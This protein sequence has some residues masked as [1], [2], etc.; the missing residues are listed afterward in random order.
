MRS[1]LP[2]APSLLFIDAAVQ[3]YKVLMD[4]ARSD[5][6]VFLIDSRR[7]GIAQITD[8]LSS[9]HHVASLHLVSHG[10]E[11]TLYL[12]NT[13]LSA[14]NLDSYG[15]D[16]Q[17]WGAALAP[18]ADVML[19]GCNVAAG[20]PGRA[21]VR[22]LGKL[23]GAK[24]AASSNLTGN[25]ALGGD[26]NLE[27]TTGQI[28]TPLAFKASIKRNYA[29]VLA[30]FT[31]TSTSDSGS[32]SLRQA[33]LDANANAGADRILF[34][35]SGGGVKTINLLTALPE[36]TGT[37][38]IDGFS[39]GGTGYSGP[40]LIRLDGAGAGSGVDGL[41]LGIDSTGSTLQGLMI[42]RFSRNGIL[43]RSN[44]NTLQGNFI[45]TDGSTTPLG[46][47]AIEQ[48]TLQ[49]PAPI[50]PN[51]TA[52]A[53]VG[54]GITI[55]A[56]A[57]NNL[58]QNNQIA[59]NIGSGIAVL[60]GTGN[61][62]QSNRLF[63]NL[64]LGIDLERLTVPLFG[65]PTPAQF[66]FGLPSG[67]TANDPGDADTG[68]NQS[69]N[70]P[71]L[72]SAVNNGTNLAIAGNLNSRPNRTYVL[73]F[74]NEPVLDA[75]GASEGLVPLGTVEVTTDNQGN[76]S[77]NFNASSST[78]GW[79]TAVAID[80][81]SGDTSEF[82]AGRF[83]TLPN[84]PPSVISPLSTAPTATAEVPVNTSQGVRVAD[85]VRGQV[86][87]LGSDR[88]G[89]A[90][91]HTS[92]QNGTW[93]YST[94]GGTTWTDFG[95]VSETAATVLLGETLLYDPSRGLTPDA[96][97]WLVFPNLDLE[98]PSNLAQQTVGNAGM[99]VNT[100][101]AS[102]D[103]TYAGYSSHMIDLTD[104]IAAAAFG[105]LPYRPV[106]SA[107]PV[108]DRNA[109]FSLEFDLQMLS[110][111][112]TR[113]G[114]RAGFSIVLMSNSRLPGDSRGLRGIELGFTTSTIFAQ[115][116]GITPQA[117]NV[118]STGLFEGEE[119]VARNTT[120]NT[121]YRV[122]VKGDRYKLLANG[123]E[124]L[125]GALRNY[126]DF[127][128]LLDPYE[129]PNFIFLGDN[130]TSAR[131]SFTLGRVALQTDNRVRFS[132]ASGQT[133]AGNLGFK[134]WDSTDGSA[135]GATGIDTTR[136]GNTSA[137]SSNLLNL[138]T[139]GNDTLSGTSLGDLLRGG[140]GR[141]ML[142]GL[143]G[144]DTL[145]GERGADLLMGSLG[146]DTLMGGFGTDTL[147]GG[148]GADLLV[149]GVG[150]DSLTGGLGRDRF[151][152]N[153]ASEGVD[154]I[155]DFSVIDDT[156][157]VSASGFGGGLVAGGPLAEGQLRLGGNAQTASERFLY[158]VRS[159]ELFFDA[160]GSGAGAAVLFA[161]LSPNLA[162]S[163]LNIVVV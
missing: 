46:N 128:F 77:F 103:T 78:R 28:H 63:S 145:M 90:V 27:F 84:T 117:P 6:D 69:Q 40:P 57:S 161:Q 143:E 163:R 139:D 42:T 152:F 140:L 121:T 141:D 136:G 47:G 23:M 16:L 4:G 162:L 151:Q 54:S 91:T 131:G 157:V 104:P 87:D 129:T 120:V 112:S 41:R 98:A 64:L 154:T 134:A 25:A 105:Q 8:V 32:G 110:E 125:A 74:F 14:D 33:I 44:G 119:S 100:A 26:W 29:G 118:P 3:D 83:I 52:T 30:D 99:T 20:E 43:V 111:V 81:D 92:S 48:V 12:G 70:F 50:L 101:I 115:G 148:R 147:Q 24:I 13:A 85:L 126:E 34:N 35:I 116:D 93:Q 153:T 53:P 19:Y 160:D 149:G 122:E 107:L 10:N 58:I 137:F 133:S 97:G 80:K 138:G 155:T 156:I 18:D 51:I 135:S 106:N 2:A 38:T 144:N 114:D 109:G 96:Q 17:I 95:A 36:I 55:A 31:V 127:D 59:F 60:T 73:E 123:I 15:W 130:T 158:R 56:N 150:T 9:Y 86:L 65:T 72:S 22:Q 21:F 68:A 49:S 71:I 37:V 113:V 7:D 146:M 142:S 67:I 79:V 61:R 94:N 89:I 82:S 76:T 102:D 159:G 62:I 88:Y 66:P 5:V 108:L 132:P 45:G 11:G 39:Q 124:I 75:I 1:H